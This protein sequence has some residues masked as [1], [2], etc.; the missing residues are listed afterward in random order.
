[1]KK[2]IDIKRQYYSYNQFIDDLKELTQTIDRPFDAII[3][4]TRGGLTIAHFLSEYYNIRR[5]Y[6]VNSISYND[7][8]KLD[9]VRVFNI[10]DLQD[11]TNI[12]IVDDIVDSGDTII[13]ILKILQEKYPKIIFYT[14]SLFYKRSAKITPTWYV[15]EAYNWIDFFWSTDL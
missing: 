6:A 5:V 3:P 11:S 14:A 4:I 7:T 1:M 10:P 9:E 15:Q 13:E 12:L 8:L 2:Q